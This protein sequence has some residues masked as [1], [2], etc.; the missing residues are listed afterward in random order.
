MAGDRL[1]LL[2]ELERVDDAVAAELVETDELYAAVEELRRR[3]LEVEG[4]FARLPGERAA[5]AKSALEAERALAEAGAAADEATAAV[6]AARS[7]GN[8]ERLAEARRREVAAQ[9]SLHVAE[10]RLE[11]ARRRA[12]ELE[13]RAEAAQSE[14]HALGASAGDLA[15]TLADRPRVP[16]GAVAD[17]GT[18]AAG[19]AEWGT[20]ARAALLVARSQA[21]AER[22]AVVR[23][24]NELGTAVLGEPLP[25]LGAR[26]VV[27]RVESG[28]HS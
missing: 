7:A 1:A 12:A 25:P 28:G 13:A 9:D 21:T 8:D 17:P 20:R 5:A 4:F 6:A 3:A 14:S 23:Q 15:S 16:G 24:A 18:S 22:D 2:R 10:R 11:A 26:E 27:R 19:V